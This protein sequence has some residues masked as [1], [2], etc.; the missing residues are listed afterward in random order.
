M[1]VVHLV[2]ST[3]F[4]GVERYIANVAT[5]LSHD[6]VEVI[7]IGGD[8]TAMR[9]SLAGTGVA[10]HE[11]NDM[12][13][14]LRSL[15]SIE[16]P[17]ILHTHMSQA[18]LVGWV[19]RRT[20]GRR[21]RHVSTRHFAG[22]R[23]GNAL[24]RA[25]FRRVAPTMAAQIAIS[26]FVAESV[27]PP[28]DLVYSGVDSSDAAADRGRFVLAAQRLEPEKQTAEVIEAWALSQG[29]H[30][31]WT[32]RIAGD[33]SEREQLETL[34][35]TRGVDKS[36]EFLGHRSDMPALLGSAAMV[37]APT[38]REGLGIL[39]LEA[40]AEATPVVAS[41]GGGHLET[42]G[43]V[44]PELLYAPGDPAAAARV[45]DALLADATLRTTVGETL[46]S[47]QRERFSLEQQVAGTR[48]VYERIL[49]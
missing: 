4:A 49:S 17:D 12:R 38:P 25:V 30:L 28:V 47:L 2:C 36:I 24:S 27:E 14:A 6:G 11:G 19:D 31:G 9:E 1:R 39:V 41:A 3:G 16:V 18:D 32:L 34:A 13:T 29:P 8:Q 46:R 48:A 26:K 10:W 40:M 43:A 21:A 33:G 20:R 22:L 45:I 7:V 37:V 35:R 44:A 5:G 42:V 15:R 23:G